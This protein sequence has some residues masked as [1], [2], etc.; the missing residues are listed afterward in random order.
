MK[1]NCHLWEGELKSVSVPKNLPCFAGA[2]REEALEL[3][4]KWEYG[5]PPPL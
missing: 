1:P 2:S 5:C 3:L 4:W